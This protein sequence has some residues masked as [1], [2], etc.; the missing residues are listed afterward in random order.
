MRVAQPELR[1]EVEPSRISAYAVEGAVWAAFTWSWLSLRLFLSPANLDG[2]ILLPGSCF[3]VIS[4]VLCCAF[5]S[6]SRRIEASLFQVVAGTWLA[7]LAAVVELGTNTAACQRYLADPWLSVASLAVSLAFCTVQTLL[8]AASVAPDLFADPRHLWADAYLLFATAFY[9]ALVRET[10]VVATAVVLALNLLTMA[11]LGAKLWKLPAGA[12]VGTVTAQVFLES[13]L[14]ASQLTALIAALGGGYAAGM[15]SFALLTLSIPAT[16]TITVR[17][18]RAVAPSAATRQP[19]DPAPA[20]EGPSEEPVQP[21]AP[22]EPPA[23]VALPAMLPVGGIS[24]DALLFGRA[25]PM[26]KILKKT[27]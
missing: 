15:T 7:C 18:A 21:S 3:A 5:P 24:G 8:S 9:A 11:C 25:K 10:Q 22:P 17:L 14:F 20:A 26:A 23:R 12:V 13:S 1:S 4:L 2:W 19:R 6:Q 16:A 27:T